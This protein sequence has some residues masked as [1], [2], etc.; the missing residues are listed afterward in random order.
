M[1]TIY[2]QN[3]PLYLVN[4]IGSEVEDY[5]HRRETIFI[6]ELN[7]AAVKTMLHEMEQP[8][9]YQGVFL[10][11]NVDELLAAF[12]EQLNVIIAAGGLVHTLQNDL[13]LIH[14]LGRWDLPKGKLDEGEN[15][16]D[17]A[18]REIKEETGADGLAIEQPLL[19]TYH[20]YHQKGKNNLKESHWYLIKAAERSP[21]TPQTEE[22]VTECIWVPIADI[23]PYID[24]AFASIADVLNAGVKIL[25]NGSK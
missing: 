12:K 13:L 4:R 14:R 20:T 1:V 3:K 9:F 7:T 22:D 23:Q 2:I 17:C 5:L 11:P 19:I 24:G 25:N 15:I 6:D 16:E 18:L 21:L 8:E 10:H